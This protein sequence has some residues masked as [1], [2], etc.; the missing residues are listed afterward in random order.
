MRIKHVLLHLIFKELLA[1]KTRKQKKGNFMNFFV[2]KFLNENFFISKYMLLYNI[3]YFNIII[4]TYYVFFFQN[5]PFYITYNCFYSKSFYVEVIIFC[6]IR[7]FKIK[8]LKCKY[9]F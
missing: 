3:L 8:N 7:L 9:K 6:K 4:I 5:I 2:K 1:V